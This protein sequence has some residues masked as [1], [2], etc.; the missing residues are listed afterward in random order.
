[1]AFPGWDSLKT[2]EKVHFFFESLETISLAV[3]IVL[4]LAG[5]KLPSDI[6]W[7]VLIVSDAGRW[8]FG[9]REKVLG[10]LEISRLQDTVGS[11][12]SA[13]R[14]NE[15]TCEEIKKLF[16]IW[17]PQR[18][19][20]FV[21]DGHMLEVTMLTEQFNSLFR[22]CDCDCRVWFSTG[23]RLQGAGV[24]VA[25]WSESDTNTKFLASSL[26]GAIHNGGIACSGTAGFLKELVPA[27]DVHGYR[28]WEPNNVADIRIQIGE[29]QLVPIQ[30]LFPVPK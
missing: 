25:P 5:M 14:L 19:D 8:I 13:R 2:V 23:H 22:S 7:V 12:S 17:G 28:Q 21:F 9:H 10:E 20:L 27:P 24:C 1:M 26:M 29:R 16:V 11:F 3:A 18:I 15:T 4:E 6:A 30:N